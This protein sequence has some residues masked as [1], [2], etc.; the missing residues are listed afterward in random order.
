MDAEVLAQLQDVIAREV[1]GSP[2]DKLQRTE[3][4]SVSS[5]AHKVYVVVVAYAKDNAPRFNI[6]VNT[7]TPSPFEGGSD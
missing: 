7:A 4:S 6:D 5:A 3:A 2:W 1:F